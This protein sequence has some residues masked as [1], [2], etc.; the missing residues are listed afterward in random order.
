MSKRKAK[1]EQGFSEVGKSRKIE[2]VTSQLT[3]AVDVKPQPAN[4]EYTVGWIC[5]IG[6]E[7]VATQCLL[8]ESHPPPEY[9]HDQDHNNTR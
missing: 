1:Y 3:A 8:D 5:A 9:V 6:T 7:Y 2:I 4:G